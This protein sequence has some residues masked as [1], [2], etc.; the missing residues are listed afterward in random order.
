VA[1]AG[2]QAQMGWRRGGGQGESQIL[3]IH[4]YELRA[5]V[6][7]CVRACLPACLPACV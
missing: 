2:L 4:M 5:N 6:R 3:K 1:I 7:A